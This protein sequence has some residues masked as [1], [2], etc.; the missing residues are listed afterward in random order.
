MNRTTRKGADIRTGRAPVWCN[1]KDAPAVSVSVAN[2]TE[3][4]G[5]SLWLDGWEVSKGNAYTATKRFVSA[6]GIDKA[7]ETFNA[8]RPVSFVIGSASKGTM[9]TVEGYATKRTYARFTFAWVRTLHTAGAPAL[10]GWSEDTAREVM[11]Y[12]N[13]TGRNIGIADMM[14]PNMEDMDNR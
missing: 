7:L 12:A 9:D 11:E 4:E 1:A 8:K 10:K 13:R 3:T 14:H 2:L 6:Q 5:A